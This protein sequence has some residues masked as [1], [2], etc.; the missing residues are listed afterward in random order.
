MAFAFNP[1]TGNFDLKGS[2]GGGGSAFFA[3][4]VATYADLPLD[5]TAALNSRWLVRSNS[6]TWP[7]SSYKQAGVYVRKATVGSSRDN[8]Y[9][10]TDTSFFDVM[11]DAAFLLF[12]DGDA[13]KNLKFQLSGISAS[14]TRTL[15]VPNANGTIALTSQLAETRVYTANDTWTKPAGAKLIHFLLIAGGGGGG[16]GRRGASGTLRTGGG[17]GSGGGITVGWIPESALGSTETVTVGSGGAGGVNSADDTSGQAG[18]DGGATSFGSVIAAY[19]GNG[20]AGGID[21][22][23]TVAGGAATV[24]SSLWYATNLSLGSGG[25]ATNGSGGATALTVA[26]PTGGGGGAGISAANAA[27]GNGGA[28][29]GIGQTNTGIFGAVATNSAAAGANG[30][31]GSTWNSYVGTGGGGAR[32]ANTTFIPFKGGNGGLYGAGGGGGSGGLN[33]SGGT[34]AGGDGA[35]GIV[36]I[37]TYF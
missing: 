15:T 9:Q 26:T 12:D 34:T 23:A 13:T 1:L 16:A 2:G 25:P 20:G 22:G 17:G 35:Q 33:A 36:V 14:T 19:R 5:G 31:N 10:L 11:S 4:E 21:S 3:G 6:G 7:F 27:A 28:V 8:D 30:A 18:A 32:M 37:T 29:N 24:N